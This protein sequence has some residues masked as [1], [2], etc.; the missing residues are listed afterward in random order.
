MSFPKFILGDNSNHPNA[1]YVIHTEFPRFII[2]L[3]DD[4]IEWLE[5]FSP[6]DENE[7]QTEA[8]HAIQQASSFYDEEISK[9][10]EET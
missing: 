2:N 10:T 1:I 9:Y 6:E 8:E 4:N 7:L 3:E 5:E